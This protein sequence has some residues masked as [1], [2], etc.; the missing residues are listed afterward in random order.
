MTF[1]REPVGIKPPK[2][3]PRPDY[4]AAVRR[5]PCVI[6][7]A[8]GMRQASRTEAHHPI[9]GRHGQH[10]ASDVMAIPL[11]TDHHTGFGFAADRLAIHRDR[12]EWVK[13]YGPDTDFIA[14]TQDRLA[15]ILEGKK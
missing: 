13:H 9:C 1:H 5:L 14:P 3:E 11:C 2:P 4:L 8:Y 15:H 7:D 10:R 12:L 6:Y